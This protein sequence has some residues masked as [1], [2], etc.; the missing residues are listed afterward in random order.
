MSS[1]RERNLHAGQRT[2]TPLRSPISIGGSESTQQRM[3]MRCHSAH[4]FHSTFVVESA[5]GSTCGIQIWILPFL[6]ISLPFPLF[7]LFLMK[8]VRWDTY[9]I[10]CI[11]VILLYLCIY[12][13]LEKVTEDRCLGLPFAAPRPPTPRLRCYPRVVVWYYS[14]MPYNTCSMY[15]NPLSSTIGLEFRVFVIPQLG[16][17]G[18]KGEW[19]H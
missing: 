9:V 17:V 1:H 5:R 10:L 2:H 3:S 13:E 19:L 8:E 15:S 12:S 16:V 18:L 11:A 14:I 6:P 7:P 4:G